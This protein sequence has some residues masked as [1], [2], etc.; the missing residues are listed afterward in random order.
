[1]QAR[2]TYTEKEKLTFLA[3]VD[4]FSESPPHILQSIAKIVKP[5]YIPAGQLVFAKGEEGKAMYII[6]QGRV[7]IH[8]KK[9]VFAELAEKKIFGEYS[10]LDTE[11]RS[12]SVTTLEDTSFFILEQDALHNTIENSTD[13]ILSIMKFLVKRLRQHNVLEEKL[14]ESNARLQEAKQQV[15]REK[16]Q[17]EA[18]N[19]EI[20]RQLQKITYQ[21]KLLEDKNRKITDS[22]NYAENI[23]SAMLPS[24]LE[25]AAPFR[26]FFVLFQ[27]R[28]VVSGDFYWFQETEERVYIAAADCTGHGVPGALMSMASSMLLN[29]IVSNQQISE[30][31]EILTQLNLGVQNFLQQ[32]KN[33]LQD[34]MDISLACL[35]KQ[36]NRVDLVGAKRPIFYIQAEEMCLLKGSKHT[37]GGGRLH[38][39]KTYDKTS[40]D[41]EPGALKVYLFSDGY[42]DQM[43]EQRQKFSRKKMLSLLEQNQHLSMQQQR[44]YLEQEIHTWMGEDE[45][46]DDILV[47]GFQV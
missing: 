29:E 5:V 10:L 32:S 30:V 17:V 7:K 35:H 22:I 40:L 37:I 3:N 39:E 4:I 20:G 46:I 45:Q 21:A 18:L 43:N 44:K 13:V 9:Y 31:D 16:E 28:D 11:A 8:D 34:G 23:Q 36:K 12:T 25:M 47:I 19:Q 14:A 15:E 41:F 6:V 1:M 38:K 26:D 2:N 27:P 33:S 42:V 24:L